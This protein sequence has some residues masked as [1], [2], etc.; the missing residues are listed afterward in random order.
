MIAENINILSEQISEKCSQIGRNASDITLI[1]VSKHNPVS[2]IIEAYNSGMRNF[3]ENK[4]QELRDKDELIEQDV[5]WHFIGHLQTNKIKYI[6]KSAEYIHSVESIKLAE[7]INKKAAS[8]G[9]VQKIMIECN[10]S[11]EE[12]KFGIHSFEDLC[13][14]VA[15]IRSF[16]NIKVVGLMTMAPYT[17]D[18]EIIRKCFGGLRLWRDKLNEKGFELTELSMGMTNDYEIALEEGATMLRIGSA[19]FGERDY[20]KTW[21]DQ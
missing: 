8:I 21:K 6:I 17:E 18:E 7:E 1:A 2:S 16:E 12:S 15:E 11:G 19:I 20:N 5:C 3:G 13:K 10:T 14:F 9:K 4:A